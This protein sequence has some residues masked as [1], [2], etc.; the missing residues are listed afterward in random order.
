M[1]GIT[2]IHAI[3]LPLIAQRSADG[4]GGHH[5]EG[6]RTAIQD[7]G[8]F[9]LG[10]YLDPAHSQIPEKMNQQKEDILNKGNQQQEELENDYNCQYINGIGE[11]EVLLTQ[12][13]LRERIRSI[14]QSYVELKTNFMTYLSSIL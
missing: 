5:G 11:V 7:G 8:V 4:I 13:M 14:E 1:T 2:D 9:G 10:S 12:D 3:Q 6:C